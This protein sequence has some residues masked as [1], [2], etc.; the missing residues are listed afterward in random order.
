M[1]LWEINIMVQRPLFLY[2]YV[3]ELKAHVQN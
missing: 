2:Y 3:A 1:F